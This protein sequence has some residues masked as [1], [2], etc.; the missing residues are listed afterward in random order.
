MPKID[1]ASLPGLDTALG[2]FGS[3]TAGGGAGPDVIVEIM[4][5]LYETEPSSMLF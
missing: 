2:L 1:I 3:A 4:V 5:F